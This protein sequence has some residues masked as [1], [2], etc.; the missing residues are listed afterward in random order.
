[1]QVRKYLIKIVKADKVEIDISHETSSFSRLAVT[2]QIVGIY[3]ARVLWCNLFNI[4]DLGIA[5]NSKE[6]EQLFSC[7]FADDNT[8]RESLN[9]DSATL[10][11]GQLRIVARLRFSFINAH[12][13]IVKCG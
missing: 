5:E 8:S 10:P 1:M 2:K 3:D 11:S 7:Q 13:V 6:F 12:L 4:D 9:A